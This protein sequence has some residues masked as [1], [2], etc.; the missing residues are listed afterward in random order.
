MAI[1]TKPKKEIAAEIYRFYQFQDQQ[2]VWSWTP[3]CSLVGKFIKMPK[4]WEG[5]CSI[6]PHDQILHP[7]LFGEGSVKKKKKT[8]C[9][10]GLHLIFGWMSII[11]DPDFDPFTTNNY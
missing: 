3:L 5:V 7:T 9:K 8:V 2:I 6:S 4:M 1:K 10:N 11:P